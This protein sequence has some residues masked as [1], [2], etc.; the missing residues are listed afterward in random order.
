MENGEDV[1]TISDH[2]EDIDA[3]ERRIVVIPFTGSM[4]DKTLFK[5]KAYFLFNRLLPPKLVFS[6]EGV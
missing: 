6:F 5:C 2:M 1:D 3:D 4:T